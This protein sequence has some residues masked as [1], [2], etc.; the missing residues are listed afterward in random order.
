[1]GSLLKASYLLQSLCD[2]FDDAGTVVFPRIVQSK[3]VHTVSK[4]PSPVDLQPWS[5]VFSPW[6]DSW[7]KTIWLF[8]Q[9][10]QTQ[11]FQDQLHSVTGSEVTFDSSLFVSGF[12]FVFNVCMVVQSQHGNKNNLLLSRIRAAE[13]RSSG[14]LGRAN[15]AWSSPSVQIVI[16]SV[17]GSAL[18][19][20][21]LQHIVRSQNWS[22]KWLRYICN[23]PSFWSKLRVLSERSFFRV[24]QISH[25]LNKVLSLN[26]R[27]SF[28]RSW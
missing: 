23:A 18:S 26:R 12:L 11:S 20:C 6:M 27:I 28:Q 24:W 19:A 25:W 16:T 22:C 14:C 8:S 3:Y 2:N 21:N 7:L 17:D 9:R 1:M 15:L 4:S 5:L 10:N 13:V